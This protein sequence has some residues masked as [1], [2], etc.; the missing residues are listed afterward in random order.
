[1][2]GEERNRTNKIPTKEIKIRT[3]P[4]VHRDLERLVETGYFGK[5]ASE[6]ADLVLREGLRRIMR[7]EGI[8]D[9]PGEK[10]VRE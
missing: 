7:E 2:P 9:Q 4:H 5:S 8:P 6:A 1:M 10:R 3:T